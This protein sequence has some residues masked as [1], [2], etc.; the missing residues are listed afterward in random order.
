MRR[1]QMKKIIYL[2]YMLILVSVIFVHMGQ[3]SLANGVYDQNTAIPVAIFQ[4]GEERSEG[5]EDETLVREVV[6]RFGEQLQKVSLLAPD[7]TIRESIREYYSDLLT[8]TL[9]QQWLENPRSAPGRWTSSP[10]PKR[11]DIESMQRTDKDAF[12]VQGK[13]IEVTSADKKSG[14]VA[15]KRAIMLKVIRLEGRWL[16]DQVKLGDN[17]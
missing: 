9:L 4:S 6:A 11:I 5:R 16:I 8:P 17:E 15:A 3:A 10:W 1:I 7:D 13:I 12:A 2:F 14:A